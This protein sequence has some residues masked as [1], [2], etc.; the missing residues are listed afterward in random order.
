MINNKLQT[1]KWIPINKLDMSYN[2]YTIVVLF[3]N[4][5]VTVCIADIDENGHLVLEAEHS[6]YYEDNDITH[7]MVLP[8]C[9]DPKEITVFR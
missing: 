3:N 8:E 7:F 9:P 2:G 6:D 4:N 5:S 1:G